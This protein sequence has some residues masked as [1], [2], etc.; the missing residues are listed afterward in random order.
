MPESNQIPEIPPENELIVQSTTY[1]ATNS[2][3][4][5]TIAYNVSSTTPNGPG[6]MTYPRWDSMEV[7]TKLAELFVVCDAWHCD[8]PGH[9]TA[10]TARS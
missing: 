10:P 8:M 6:A 5:S 2:G 7:F 9:T 4:L 1:P 3:S